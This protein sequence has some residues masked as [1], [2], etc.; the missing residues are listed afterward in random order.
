MSSDLANP[1]RRGLLARLFGRTYSRTFSAR[2][3]R[4]ER[5]DLSVPAGHAEAARA[6]V[7]R[8]LAG[9]DVTAPVTAEDAGEGKSRIRV[10]LGADDAAKIN[11][12]DDDVQSELE[13][14]L[15][16]AMR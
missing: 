8:W 9:H 11:F 13:N 2:V 1:E 6:A 15:V 4:S 12:A 5:L 3:T 10:E 16:E 7:E 14:V